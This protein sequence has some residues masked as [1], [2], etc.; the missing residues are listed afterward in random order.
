MRKE[1][2]WL[3]FTITMTLIN[4][5]EEIDVKSHCVIL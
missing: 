3:A 2:V 1:Y 5:L 4:N